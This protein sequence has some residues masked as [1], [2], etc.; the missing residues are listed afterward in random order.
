MFKWSNVFKKKIKLKLIDCDY[1]PKDMPEQ[2]PIECTILRTIQGSDR[3]DYSIAVCNKSI[4][5]GEQVIRYLVVAPRFI[6]EHIDEGTKEI[7]FGVAYV[8]DDSL[9]GD[10]II[11]FEKCKYVAICRAVRVDM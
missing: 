11:S 10:E 3:S 2:L 9:I 8:L 4:H 1:A 7:T 5:F 6:G